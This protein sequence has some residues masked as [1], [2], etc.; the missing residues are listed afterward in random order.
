MGRGRQGPRMVQWGGKERSG[1]AQGC[2]GCRLRARTWRLFSGVFVAAC[3]EPLKSC[4]ES[5]ANGNDF[6]RS[7]QDLD[8]TMV[9]GARLCLDAAGA[10]L[11][12]GFGLRVYG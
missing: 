1:L 10:G 8:L 3:F 4:S 2:K 6:Q 5:T 11:D 9:I 12:V 7:T